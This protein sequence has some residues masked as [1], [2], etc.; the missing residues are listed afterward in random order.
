MILKVVFAKIAPGVKVPELGPKSLSLCPLFLI[1][2][3]MDRKSYN[4]T[5][6]KVAGFK[7]IEEDIFGHEMVVDKCPNEAQNH[8]LNYFLNILRKFW[9]I[10]AMNM[11]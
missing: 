2:W 10:G 6:F 9:V 1:I 5:N 8:F 11:A 3:S 7:S 4:M